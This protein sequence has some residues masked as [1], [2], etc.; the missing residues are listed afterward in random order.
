M[1]RTFRST[2]VRPIAHLMCDACGNEHYESGTNWPDAL[3]KCRKSVD[4]CPARSKWALPPGKDADD[5]AISDTALN[6]TPAANTDLQTG[7]VE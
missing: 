1:S 2:G 7:G 4:E 5:P 6:L 3:M